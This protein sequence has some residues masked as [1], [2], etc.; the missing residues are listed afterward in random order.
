VFDVVSNSDSL[1][2][3]SPQVGVCNHLWH[4]VVGKFG[5]EERNLAGEDFYNF[6]ATTNYPS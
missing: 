1:G 2:D 4:G 3:F 6:V 5:I